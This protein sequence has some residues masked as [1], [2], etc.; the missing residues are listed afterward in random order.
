M[1]INDFVQVELHYL[2]AN[3]GR[4]KLFLE[5]QITAFNDEYIVLDGKREVPL[6]KE[7]ATIKVL[8]NVIRFP[9]I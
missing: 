5:G 4:Q 7:L 2:A 1:K 8:E 3:F 9:I 6:N